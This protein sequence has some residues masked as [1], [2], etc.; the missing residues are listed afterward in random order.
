MRQR[1]VSAL[2]S[3]VA[4]EPHQICIEG[5]VSFVLGY[6]Q[7]AGKRGGDRATSNVQ[8]AKSKLRVGFTK[9]AIW[10]TRKK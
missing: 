9:I 4:T 7:C 3:V 1:A 8:S 2:E 5:R 6:S 10:Q